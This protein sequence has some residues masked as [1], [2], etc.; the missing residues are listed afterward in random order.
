VLPK[1]ERNKLGEILL[2]ID[3][4]DSS[5]HGDLLIM[6]QITLTTAVRLK[7]GDSC[8]TEIESWRFVSKEKK[9]RLAD[10]RS[11]ILSLAA[12][13]VTGLKYL[14]EWHKVRTSSRRLLFQRTA[15]AA[16]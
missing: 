6:L 16:A 5:A 4:E 12:A 9:Q 2:V 8:M 3:D 14:G 10:D 15:K 7:L 1:I 11:E 13:E